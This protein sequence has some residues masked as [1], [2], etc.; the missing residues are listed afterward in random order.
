M[1]FTLILIQSTNLA[2]APTYFQAKQWR[3][4]R[5]GLQEDVIQKS[6]LDVLECRLSPDVNDLRCADESLPVAPW[7]LTL[8][9]G[10]RP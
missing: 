8:T 3:I 6:R 1:Y 2:L 5:L 7:G 4:F 9:M 10:S